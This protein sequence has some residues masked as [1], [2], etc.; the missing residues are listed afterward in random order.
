MEKKEILDLI[1]RHTCTAIP[2]LKNH[3]FQAEDRFKDLGA[4]SLDRAEILEMVMTSLSLDIPRVAIFGAKD[5]GA[6]VDVLY[7]A[8]SIEI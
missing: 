6:L 2:I 5:I 1:V 7:E 3:T 8:V 4:S